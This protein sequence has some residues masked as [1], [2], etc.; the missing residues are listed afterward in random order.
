[1]DTLYLVF[2][3][4]S[5]LSLDCLTDGIISPQANEDFNPVTSPCQATHRKT[6]GFLFKMQKCRP[7]RNLLRQG[8]TFMCP[9][10]PS[11]SNSEK[12]LYYRKPQFPNAHFKTWLDADETS[13]P[14]FAFGKLKTHFCPRRLPTNHAAAHEFS[15]PMR[16][17]RSGNSRRENMRDLLFPIAR[18]AFNRNA[19]TD[20][21]ADAPASP[22]M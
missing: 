13:S 22:E 16:A 11:I 19:L 18:P 14:V 4:H 6:L 10:I 20:S 9:W 8:D 3:H 21:L 12:E 15:S 2:K 17:K 1:M 7:A 5:K